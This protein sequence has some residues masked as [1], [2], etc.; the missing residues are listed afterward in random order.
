[1]E[2]A[3]LF[4]LPFVVDRHTDARRRCHGLFPSH[5]SVIS[6]VFKTSGPL[7]A[8]ISWFRIS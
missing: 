2:S 6:S 5:E 4:E 1:M 3:E 7:S 8:E